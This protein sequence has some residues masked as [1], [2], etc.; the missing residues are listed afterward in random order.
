[1]R[2]A[3]SRRWSFFR[4]G[5]AAA[6]LAREI[7]AHHGAV[8]YREV[9]EIREQILLRELPDRSARDS[10]TADTTARQS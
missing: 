4:S 6:E 3:F 2:R 10:A 9:K 1:V 8:I 5:A 7:D